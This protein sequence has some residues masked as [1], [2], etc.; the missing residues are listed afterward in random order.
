MTGVGRYYTQA[1]LDE[2]LDRM[3]RGPCDNEDALRAG[4]KIWAEVEA[5]QAAEREATA[6]RS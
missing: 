4:A 3:G 5:E 1:Q 2:Y 6:G